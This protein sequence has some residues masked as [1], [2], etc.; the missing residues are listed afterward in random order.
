M[1]ASNQLDK[2]C[3]KSSYITLTRRSRLCAR[4]FTSKSPF[5][6]AYRLSDSWI[7]H[8]LS[9][10]FHFHNLISS[11]TLADRSII[12]YSDRKYCGNIFLSMRSLCSIQRL[13]NTLTNFRAGSSEELTSKLLP[14]HHEKCFLW[15]FLNI[16]QIISETVMTSEVMKIWVES[17][18]MECSQPKNILCIYVAF[19]LWDDTYMFFKIYLKD[20]E[21]T[22]KSC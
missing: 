14:I 11:T 17:L 5:N 9:T 4:D 18:W 7:S 21:D 12:I 20:H 8:F 2:S 22:K 3:H 16:E 6:L 19:P 15:I 10:A 13:T 1:I